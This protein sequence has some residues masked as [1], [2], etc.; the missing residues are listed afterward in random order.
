MTYSHAFGKSV[1][2]SAS[3]I[4]IITP[5]YVSPDFPSRLQLFDKCVASVN[6]L[7]RDGTAHLHIVVDDGSPDPG[8]IRRVL[9]KYDDR[10][11]RYLRR[12]RK[13]TDLK[14][15]S[16]AL[17]FGI[18]AVLEGH[19]RIPEYKSI[20]SVTPLHSDDLMYDVSSRARSLEPAGVGAALGKIAVCR[21]GRTAIHEPNFTMRARDYV[22]RGIAPYPV[23]SIM[24]KPSALEGMKKYNQEKLPRNQRFDG[25]YHPDFVNVE[26]VLV[27]KLTALYLC[28][29][30]LRIAVSEKISMAYHHHEDSLRGYHQ[31]PLRGKTRQDLWHL[32]ES[33]MAKMY[34]EI[35]SWDHL[36]P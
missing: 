14:T 15:A 29:T 22:T 7:G 18:D 16:N 1:V 35:L 3:L 6:K 28:K 30:D 19:E 12:E 32:N 31:D 24:W 4:A 17:N 8:G 9:K 36:N 26:D 33:I 5:V 10:R 2:Y 25:V 13:K 21:D 27:T 34:Y 11:I 20:S 23:G